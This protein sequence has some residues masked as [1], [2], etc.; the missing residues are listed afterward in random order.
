MGAEYS[1][2][3]Q[4]VTARQPIVFTQAPVPCNE[5]FIFHRDGTGLFLA[6]SRG[7]RPYRQCCRIVIPQAL[8]SVNV[9]ATV[10]IPTDGTVDTIRLAL[11]VDGE[12]ETAGTMV[13]TPAAVEEPFTINTSSIIAIPAI[14]G[15]SSVSVRNIG[16]EDV[17]VLS[18][19][20]TFDT[21]GVKR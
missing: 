13:V 3:D 16:T 15:C 1:A 7:L 9:N 4:I 2:I 10:Q 17:E 14:C 6:S 8:Y 21:A 12:A 11:F 5:G 20:I 18:A 19:S